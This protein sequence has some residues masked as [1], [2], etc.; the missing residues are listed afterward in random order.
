LVKIIFAMSRS[1]SLNPKEFVDRFQKEYIPLLIKHYRTQMGCICDLADNRA[2]NPNYMG[3]NFKRSPYDGITA[4]YFRELDEF[5]NYYTSQQENEHLRAQEER[6][7]SETHVYHLEEVIHWDNLKSRTAGVPSPGFKIIPFS[8][9]NPHFSKEEFDEHYRNVHSALARE[10][11]PGIGRY[12]QN[13]VQAPLSAMAP[14]IDAFAELHFPTFEDY[15][16]RFYARAESTKIIGRDLVSFVDTTK[17]HYLT[18]I[19]MI[20]EKPY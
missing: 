10:H 6:L 20:I 15:R 16:D 18:A 7:L 11:H 9:R 3:P 13:F 2:L 14:E 17:S 5:L 19:E 4:L 8:C 1:P 12:V